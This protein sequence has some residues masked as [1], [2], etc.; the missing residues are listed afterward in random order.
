MTR[1][2]AAIALVLAATSIASLGSD[3]AATPSSP[4]CSR[5]RSRHARDVLDEFF[6]PVVARNDFVLPPN[7]PFG[8]DKDMY[9]EH[10]RHKE[11]V[12]RTQYKSL[13]SDKVFKSEYY[14][15]KHMDNRHMDKIPEGADTCL[16]DYCDV[17]RCDEHREWKRSDGR[18]GV[19][20]IAWA[21]ARR[22]DREKMRG[23]RHHC[24]MLMHRCFPLRVAGRRRRRRRASL[25]LLL[26]LRGG[27]SRAL[28]AAPLRVSHVRIGAAHVRAPVGSRRGRSKR[29]GTTSRWGSWGLS[30]RRTISGGRRGAAAGGASFGI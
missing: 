9:L 2:A 7:C 29:G 17:L 25:L 27:A 5:E 14:V 1:F 26:R 21:T 28:H 6:H 4:A 13:Y 24:E 10:E 19:G 20:L 12:R 15:D 8:R 18:G 11:V 23:V 22:C 30:S 16:L 3:A